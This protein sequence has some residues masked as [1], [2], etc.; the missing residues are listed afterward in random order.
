MSALAVQAEPQ[1]ELDLSP[2]A[3]RIVVA[4]SGGVDSSVAAALLAEA[5]FD[6]VGIT[7][8]LYDAGAAQRRAGACCAG[9]DI[10]DARR[11][12]EHLGINHYVLDYESRFRAAVIDDFADAYA[13]GETPIPCVRCN[14]TVKFTDLLQVARDLGAAALV[15]GHYVRRILGAHG[16]ELHRAVDAERDQSYFLF[17]TT[18]EQLEYLRFP[19]GALSKTET[20]RHAE[21]L[22]LAVANKRDSQDICFVPDGRYANIVA[23]L[24]PEAFEPGDIAHVDGRLLGR[25]GGVANFTVGQRRGLGL[26]GGDDGELRVVRLDAPARRVIVG[27]PDALLESEMTVRDLNWLG[28]CPL[29]ADG[30]DVSVKVRS[31]QPAAPA[32]AFALKDGRA[33]VVL[34]SALQSVAPGQA[35]VMYAG[36]RVLGGGWIERPAGA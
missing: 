25:H 19:L 11:I 17:A 30:L 8:Q 6:V 5:G 14:Q 18:R 20:R 15:T 28:D 2:T 26:G 34:G 32:R 3:G 12:A 13:A 27:P 35:C 7:L 23:K 16:A 29:P 31:S 1:I 9:Q 4:M 22:G 24:R 21:R 33:R 10:L 36:E